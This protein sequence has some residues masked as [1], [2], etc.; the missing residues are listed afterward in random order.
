[1]KQGRD[2][3]RFMLVCVLAA[4]LI[5]GPLGLDVAAAATAD[6]Q[7]QFSPAFSQV[8]DQYQQLLESGGD[9]AFVFEGS[10]G[11]WEAIAGMDGQQALGSI[12][13]ALV[14]ISGDDVPELLIGPMPGS[15]GDQGRG[16]EIF[17]AYALIQGEAQLMVEG[18][19]R[20]HYYYLGEGRLLNQGSGGAMHSIFAAYR[21]S[22]DGAGLTCQDYYFTY[23]KPD[24][25]EQMAYY[26]N[27]IGESDTAQ[28][29]QL[30]MAEAAF[31]QIESALE[32]EIQQLTL[33]PFSTRGQ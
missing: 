21:L 7:A 9:D 27:Q 28:S 17:A 25:S 26:H 14:D 30:D 19:A 13:Y 29:T 32:Q 20:N 10:L 1:M 2:I 6:P 22:P 24:N 18:W 12:G 23:E 15:R 11:V 8:L 16:S 31:W 5:I 4:A 3:G 33:I